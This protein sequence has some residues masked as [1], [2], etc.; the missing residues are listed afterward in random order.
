MRQTSA[1]MLILFSYGLGAEL[2]AGPVLVAEEGFNNGLPANLAVT[3]DGISVINSS[4]AFEGSGYLNLQGPSQVGGDFA[5]WSVP[6]TGFENLELSGWYRIHSA[7][8]EGDRFAI[9]WTEGAVI[10]GELFSTGPAVVGDWTPVSFNL[11]PAANN[12]PDL[13]IVFLLEAGSSADR[14]LVDLTSVRQVPEPA[15]LTLL[16]LGAC[17]F[18][19]RRR[20]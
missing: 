15:T 19:R 4:L 6:T 2:R 18:H 13:G 9:L 1:V 16:V 7:L 20:Q 8:E 14:V 3:G 5:L 12:N 17:A 10:Q 11:P